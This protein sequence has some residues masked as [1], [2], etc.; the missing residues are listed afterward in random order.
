MSH[1][2]GTKLGPCEIVGPLG[3]KRHPEGDASNIAGGTGSDKGSGLK[4]TEAKLSSL[5]FMGLKAGLT[6]GAVCKV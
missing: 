4:F 6:Q 3:P 5:Y 2:S 1:A